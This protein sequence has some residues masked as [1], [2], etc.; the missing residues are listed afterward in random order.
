MS[1]EEADP[2]SLLNFYRRL[3]G[4]RNAS[5][6]LQAGDYTLLEAGEGGCLAYTRGLG[7]ERWLIILNFTAQPAEFSLVRHGLGG[8]S[9]QPVILEGEVDRAGRSLTI[10]PYGVNLLHIA[11]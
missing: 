9:W 8:L 11:G 1:A 5:P 10:A 3:I 2:A 7:A 4:L 6:A